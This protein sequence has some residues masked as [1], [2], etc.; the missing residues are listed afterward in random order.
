MYVFKHYTKRSL[1]LGGFT[2][3]TIMRKLKRIHCESVTIL[4]M[5]SPWGRMEEED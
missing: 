5:V 2:K 4:Y 1:L 3:G